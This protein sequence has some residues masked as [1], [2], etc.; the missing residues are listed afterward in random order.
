MSDVWAKIGAAANIHAPRIADSPIRMAS[1]LASDR[2]N[3]TIRRKKR[4]TKSLFSWQSDIADKSKF[5][6]PD[7]WSEPQRLSRR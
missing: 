2:Y 3:R 6:N 1:L 7:S 4:A 5:V